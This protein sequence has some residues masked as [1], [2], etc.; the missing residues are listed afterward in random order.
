MNDYSV[1]TWLAQA[2]SADANS[3]WLPYLY[4]Y[5]VGG[6]FFLL[7]II[8]AV[9]KGALDL[10]SA[11]DRRVLRMLLLGLALYATLHGGWLF[12]ATSEN[13]AGPAEAETQTLLNNPTVPHNSRTGSR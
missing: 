1:L 4:Q 5:L 11:A 2:A 12:W 3:P 6:G 7:A 10:S 9:R 8:V 13:A